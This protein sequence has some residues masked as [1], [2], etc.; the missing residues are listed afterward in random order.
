MPEPWDP[1]PLPKRGN[2]SCR[3]LY[4][5]IGRALSTWEELETVLAGLYAAL[6]G[7]SQFDP[8]ANDGYGKELNFRSRLAALERAGCRYFM[9]NPDQTLEGELAWVIRNSAGYS[10]RR[11]DVAHGVVRLLDPRQGTLTSGPTHWCLVPPHFRGTKFS[12]PRTP[13][14]IL[15]SRE[16]N[17]FA[18]AFWPIYRRVHALAHI[19]ELPAYALRRKSFPPPPWLHSYRRRRRVRRLGRRAYRRSG[20]RRPWRREARRSARETKNAGPRNRPAF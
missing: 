20:D 5:A 10:Q 8:A 18:T 16:I 9:K 1:P 11:N 14:Y 15:T 2:K 17:G 19:V 13:V 12:T 7:H 3:A 4:E 6:C